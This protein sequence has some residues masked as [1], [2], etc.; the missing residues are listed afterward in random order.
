VTNRNVSVAAY[1]I[2]SEYPPYRSCRAPWNSNITPSKCV[3]TD[4][5]EVNEYE[6]ARIDFAKD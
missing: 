2:L 4:R 6:V 3:K 5:N 1:P